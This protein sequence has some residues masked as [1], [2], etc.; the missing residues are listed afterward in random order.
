MICAAGI[1]GPYGDSLEVPFEEFQRH[2]EINVFGIWL[3]NQA[4]LRRFVPA[5][6]GKIV[7]VA[8]NFGLVGVSEFA[9]Y[10]GGKAAVIGITKSLAVEFGRYGININAICPGAAA[11]QI[12]AHLREQEEVLELFQQETPLRIGEEGRYVAEPEEIA[13][14]ALYMASD[15]FSFGTGSA[16]VVDGG[17]IAH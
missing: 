9:A 12:N 6:A 2:F 8:S 16:F 10:C 15:E 11:T 7:N 17:W 3:C 4:A 14:A 13:S 5:R 1:I